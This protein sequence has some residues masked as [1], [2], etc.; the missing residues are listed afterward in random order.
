MKG[1]LTEAML[2]KVSEHI[3]ARMGL[4]FPPSKWPDMERAFSEAAKDYGFR[5]EVECAQ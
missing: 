4:K 5:D 2:Y 3:A 1:S